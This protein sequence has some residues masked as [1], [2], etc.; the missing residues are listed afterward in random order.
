MIKNF[1]KLVHIFSFTFFIAFNNSL[2]SQIG[3]NSYDFE[4]G[5]EVNVALGELGDAEAWSI[6]FFIAFHGDTWRNADQIFSEIEIFGWN[7]QWIPKVILWYLS[8]IWIHSHPK[9]SR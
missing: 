3:N 8:F 9:M 6:E 2:F 7:H 1:L 5:D 4:Q